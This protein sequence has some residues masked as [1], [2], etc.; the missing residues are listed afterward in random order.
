[1]TTHRGQST[2]PTC[3]HCGAQTSEVT[4]SR[5]SGDL[6]RRN[7]TCKECG[8]RS[9]TYE[10]AAPNRDETAAFKRQLEALLMQHT[11]G[12][13]ITMA[14]ARVAKAA[15]VKSTELKQGMDILED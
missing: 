8:Q 6:K 2:G 15:G 4:D 12:V 3:P 11:N 5:M 14:L 7:R 1:M 13:Q 9:T 10:I